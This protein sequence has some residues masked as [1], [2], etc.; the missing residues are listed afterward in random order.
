M[1]TRKTRQEIETLKAQLAA[2]FPNMKINIEHT[3]GER[4]VHP[5][6]VEAQNLIVTRWEDEKPIVKWEQYELTELVT[7]PNC[8]DEWKNAAIG[9]D[10][11]LC[12]NCKEAQK[13]AF[14][15][16]SSRPAYGDWEGTAEATET[17]SEFFG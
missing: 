1:A 15:V 16:V 3:T 5:L 9:E 2:V 14:K 12:H 11:S 6:A 4:E 13:S 7:C 17:A 8:G 10:V